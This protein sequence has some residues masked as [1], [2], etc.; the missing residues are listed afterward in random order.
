MLTALV[1]RVLA[2]T[3][4]PAKSPTD[5]DSLHLKLALSYLFKKIE[6][7]DEPYLIASYALAAADAG[8]KTNA[9]RA[10]E[11]LRSLAHSEGNTTYWTLETNT[12]FYGWGLAG[13]V[14]TSAL[15]IQALARTADSKTSERSLDSTDPLIRSGVL[16]LLKEKDRYGVWY[17]TQATI[18]VLDTLVSLLSTEG[19]SQAAA[20]VEVIVNGQPA[21]SITMPAGDQT[22][23]LIRT[24]ISRFLRSGQNHVELR[25]AGVAS[26][27]SVQLVSNY[28]VPWS[29]AQA[30]RNEVAANKK[31][32]SL[33]LV[34]TFDKTAAKVNEEIV[35]H[36]KAERV[37]FRGYGMML[38]EIGLPPGADVDRGSL[39]SA[40]KNS[41]WSLHQYDILPDRVVVYLWPAAGGVNFDFKFR[42]RFALKAKSAPST[43]YDYYNPESNFVI[44]PTTFEVHAEGQMPIPVRSDRAR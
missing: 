32:D 29:E 44:V 11:K 15:A 3:G 10:T 33:R 18:N 27:A 14:E 4:P 20:P 26:Y 8:D 43:I 41:G 42:P 24:D 38:A 5:D 40:I 13:R 22:A 25:R 39:E 1:A 35:C 37:G 16:F 30:A 21:T 12:P 28:Y 23:A 17:S 36:V 31:G 7:I 6:T 9:R 34:A 19:Q 2:T